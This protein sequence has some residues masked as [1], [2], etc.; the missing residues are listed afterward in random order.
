ML[1]AAYRKEYI[2]LLIIGV[3]CL[4]TLNQIALALALG[5]LAAFLVEETFFKLVAKFKIEKKYLKTCLSVALVLFVLAFFLCPLLFILIKGSTEFTTIVRSFHQEGSGFESYLTSKNLELNQILL[6]YFGF[7]F[8]LGELTQKFGSFFEKEFVVFVSSFSSI[9]TATPFM[10]IQVFVFF[11]T[12]VI[13]LINGKEYRQAIL[14][15]VIPW[16]NERKLISGTF[17]IT[18]KALII[19]NLWIALIQASFISIILAIFGI[20]NFLFLGSLGFFLSFIPVIGTAP[21][22]LGVSSWCFFYQDRPIAALFIVGA[23]LFVGLIDN[24]LRPLLM[25]G[26]FELSFY[27]I[28][29]AILGG[30]MSFGLLGA[31]FGPLVFSLFKEAYI[32][33]KKSETL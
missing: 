8:S 5:A 9:L 14:P 20:P 6:K 19:A 30:I 7:N 31:L 33:F 21:L 24:F 27:W 11:F 13:F 26:R 17:A 15:L 12:W 10:L 28:F 29:L 18:I 3:L 16:A 1:K 25:K 32:S 22:M 23:S 4:V 2:F